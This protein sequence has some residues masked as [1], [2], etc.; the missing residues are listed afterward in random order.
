MLRV[1]CFLLIFEC[2]GAG[3][4]VAIREQA[5]KWFDIQ[6]QLVI[7]SNELKASLKEKNKEDLE[8]FKLQHQIAAIYQAQ[9]RYRLGFGT[10]ILPTTNA[11]REYLRKKTFLQ[12]KTKEIIP[13]YR[14]AA[15]SHQLKCSSANM[16]KKIK[17]FHQLEALNSLHV[18][19]FEEILQNSGKSLRQIDLS[20]KRDSVAIE[21][22]KKLV[23]A[24]KIKSLDG[25]LDWVSPVAGESEVKNKIISWRQLLDKSIV[26]APGSGL[27]T[28]IGEFEGKNAVCISKSSGEY[29][30]VGISKVF[31][32]VGD[33]VK[34]K[35]PIGIYE[36]D[37]SE[38]LLE[39]R[40]YKD[41]EQ[42]EPKSYHIDNT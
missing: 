25:D 27:V 34:Q 19:L 3:T 38:D 21:K 14:A 9:K 16:E 23:S 18:K 33:C 5:L 35:D 17:Q 32:A 2:V 20:N 22:S 41:G 37:T 26:I 30:L 10:A 13:L 15:N 28:F 4:N 6:K 7:Y 29:I 24:S 8:F 31:V 39:L 1:F 12:L 11:V 36:T 40:L 42:L